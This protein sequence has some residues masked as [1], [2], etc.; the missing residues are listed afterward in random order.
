MKVLRSVLAGIFT[1][2][3]TI[4]LFVFGISLN[5]KYT[6]TDTIGEVVKKGITDNI[7]NIVSE[8]SEMAVGEIRTEVD[9]VFTDNPKVKDMVEHC[10][11]KAMDILNGKNITNLNLQNDIEKIIN[12][13]QPKLEKIGI[14]ISEED[15]QKIL[16][17]VS[18]E[19]FNNKFNEAIDKIKGNVPNEAL[20]VFDILNFF[21]SQKFR[22]IL[23][24]TFVVLLILIAL[25][26]KSFYKWLS[27]LAIATI[28][29]GILYS[30]IFG[31]ADWLL[32]GK[33]DLDISLSNFTQY[34]YIMLIVGILSIILNIVINAI[35]KKKTIKKQIKTEK[36]SN[37]YI[38][39]KK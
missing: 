26:K 9:K 18:S 39:D 21:M 1:G 17:F 22:I 38:D 6:I 25:L 11:N 23:M 33:E 13:N 19:D 12:E 10:F 4:I 37:E 24:C 20:K 30:I 31:I 5:F 2:I 27:N 15:K 3:M 14:N 28:I 35:C 16:D 34:G 29:N 36:T 7:V 32:K 8:H